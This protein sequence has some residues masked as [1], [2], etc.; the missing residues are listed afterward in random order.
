MDKKKVFSRKIRLWDF[1]KLSSISY[2]NPFGTVTNTNALN[3]F[4]IYQMINH[5][6]MVFNEEEER[7]R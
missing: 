3:P 1:D 7:N 4:Q 2:A 6:L 5:T